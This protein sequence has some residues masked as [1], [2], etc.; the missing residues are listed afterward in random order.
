MNEQMEK[1]IIRLYSELAKR[2]PTSDEYEK[3]MKRLRDLNQMHIDQENTYI[4]CEKVSK[5][6]CLNPKYIVS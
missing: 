4:E 1:E 5:S 6:I 3:L 2:D